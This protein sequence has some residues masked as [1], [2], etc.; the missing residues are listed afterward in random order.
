MAQPYD[1][2]DYW[3]T[4]KRAGGIVGD[5]AG[6]AVNAMGAINPV[7]LGLQGL[8]Q[9]FGAYDQ[10]TRPPLSAGA[11]AQPERPALNQ[12]QLAQQ[13]N[14]I[15]G[16]KGSPM[17]A[18]PAPVPPAATS[19]AIRR[20]GAQPGFN[21]GPT[22][23]AIPDSAEAAGMTPAGGVN[24]Q[25]GPAAAAAPAMTPEQRMAGAML[26]AQL[27]YGGGAGAEQDI[28]DLGGQSKQLMRQAATVR[29]GGVGN[30]LSR[31]ATIAGSGYMDKLGRDKRKQLGIERGEINEKLMREMQLLRTGRDPMQDRESYGGGV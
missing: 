22:G 1:P 25:S 31:A 16:P 18:G 26:E 20:G 13:V 3:E 28:K 4:L 2:N 23:T 12:R 21:P 14:D 27:G 9:G 19:S 5:V 10:L 24:Q 8:G 7:R 29:G 6:G 15:F 17:G 30:N 11:V